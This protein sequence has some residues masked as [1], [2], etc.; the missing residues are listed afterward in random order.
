MFPFSIFYGL[1]GVELFQLNSKYVGLNFGE[2]KF[3]ISKG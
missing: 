3:Y 2:V 1:V